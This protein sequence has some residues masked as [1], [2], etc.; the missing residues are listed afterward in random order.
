[1]ITTYI[2][3]GFMAIVGGGSTLYVIVALIGTI[4]FKLYRKIRYGAKWSD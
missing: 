2:F 1:M 4:I 3:L